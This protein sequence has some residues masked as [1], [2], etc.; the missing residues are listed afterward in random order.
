MSY[1]YKKMNSFDQIVINFILKNFWS[2]DYKTAEKNPGNQMA[3]YNAVRE[4]VGLL[5][6]NVVRL[7]TWRWMRV[8][9]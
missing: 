6:V 2:R 8:H 4:E 5:S 7:S 9:L 3:T 1:L